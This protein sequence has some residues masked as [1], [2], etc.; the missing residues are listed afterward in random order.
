MRCILLLSCFLLVGC[1]TLSIPRIDPTGQRIFLPEPYRV[2]LSDVFTHTDRNG[3]PTRSGIFPDPAYQ[4]PPTPP[5]CLDGTGNCRNPLCK[6]CCS[7]LLAD[8]G[9]RGQILMTPTR[10][11]AP[12]GG[13]VVLLAGICGEDGYLMTK[14]PLEWMLSPDSVGT[15]IEVGD[16]LKGKPLQQWHTKVKVEKRDVDYAK[17]RT[18][19][20]ETIITRGTECRDD[21]LILKKGQTWLS[22]SSPTEGMSK[23]TV[24]APDSEIWDRRRQT[25]TIYWID[26]GYTFP[27]PVTALN[28]QPATLVTQVFRSEG[29]VGAEGWKVIYRSLNPEIAKFA[30]NDAAVHEAIVD[31]DGRATAQ[32]VNV[33]G[34]PNAAIVSI[35]VVK[36]ADNENRIAEM[37]L[38]QRQVP[39]TWSAPKLLV[40]AAGPEF[41]VPG[42]LM[43]YHASLSNVGDLVSENTEFRVDVPSGMEIVSISPEINANNG[44]ILPQSRIWRIGPM[45]PRRRLDVSIVVRPSGFGDVRMIFAGR[46]VAGQGPGSIVAED[47]RPLNIRIAQPSVQVSMVP[48]DN[49]GQAEVGKEVQFNIVVVNS[50]NSALNNIKLRVNSDPGL[51]EASTN[52]NRVEQEIPFLAPGQRRELALRYVIRREGQLNAELIVSSNEAVLGKTQATARGMQA[53]QKIPGVSVDIVPV[54][55]PQDLATRDRREVKIVVGNSG[56]TPI[57]DIQ[58]EVLY[59][60]NIEPRQAS[61]GVTDDSARRRLAWRAPAA[62]NPGD[63]K[64]FLVEFAPS[65]VGGNLP[66]SGTLRANVVTAQGVTATKDF[67][68]SLGGGSVMPGNNP[69]PVLPNNPNPVLPNNPN[70]S[71]LPGGGGS[72]GLTIDIV[73]ANDPFY[74]NQAATYNITVR[75]PSNTD[76]RAVVLQIRATENVEVS[77][78]NSVGYNLPSTY[79]AM[80]VARSAPIQFLR[81]GESFQWILKVVPRAPMEFTVQAEVLS[82]GMQQP[83]TRS[84]TARALE[85]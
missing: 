25:A 6:S 28:G 9:E 30:P 11:V 50:G 12:V 36:P 2:G 72:G 23:V 84:V 21:D 64:E 37:T 27:D 32:L 31:R 8:K 17:G 57:S 20:S 66:A 43:T 61:Q 82:E 47:T 22:I 15:F 58:L 41:G 29:F 78:L 75:N 68:L 26:A 77:G 45:E 71:V 60:G 18:S 24:L 73:R 4:T 55:N 74:A 62:I 65:Q 46:G 35:E 44:Q 81:P 7:K 48:S 10:I 63:R 54:G 16:D 49:V 85:N 83:I 5:A 52:Q 14:E 39:V 69:N 1:Q 53:V 76:E 3:L 42:E 80:G 19:S 51:Q 38:A 13:E 67:T 79:P 70:N 56:Q 33:S 59:D 34:G 40:Q